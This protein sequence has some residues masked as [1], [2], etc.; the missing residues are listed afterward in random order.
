MLRK[1]PPQSSP[2][3]PVSGL[4]VVLVSSSG[5]ILVEL[6]QIRVKMIERVFV[7]VLAECLCVFYQG[8]WSISLSVSPVAGLMW[9]H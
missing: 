7:L 9:L 3:L 2:L 4:I 8:R 6:T 1:D 5:K